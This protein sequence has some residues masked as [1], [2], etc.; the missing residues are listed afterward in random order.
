VKRGAGVEASGKGD[1]D[2]LAD[3]QTF[4]NYRHFVSD[5]KVLPCTE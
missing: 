2:F 4:K 5:L 1:A 3:R